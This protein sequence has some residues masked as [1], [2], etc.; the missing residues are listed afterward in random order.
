MPAPLTYDQVKE[1][2][3]TCGYILVSAEYKSAKH[4]H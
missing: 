4:R 1:E 3:D 2:L